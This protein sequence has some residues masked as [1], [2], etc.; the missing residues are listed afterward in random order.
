ML[1]MGWC[2][3]A[4][5]LPGILKAIGRSE[6]RSDFTV[7]KFNDHDHAICILM[8]G[9]AKYFMVLRDSHEGMPPLKC[10]ANGPSVRA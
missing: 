5:L 3:Y 2:P 1:H 6:C 7:S 9:I 10:T 8:E 4:P